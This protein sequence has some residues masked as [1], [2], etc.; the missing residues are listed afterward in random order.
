MYNVLS[1]TRS[2]RFRKSRRTAARVLQFIYNLISEELYKNNTSHLGQGRKNDYIISALPF[3]WNNYR[4][5]A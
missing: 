2:S 1:S 4:H 3:E 5:Y